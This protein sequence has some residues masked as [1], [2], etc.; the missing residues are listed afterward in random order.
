MTASLDNNRRKFLMTSAG[1]GA[2]VRP[3]LRRAWRGARAQGLHGA[4]AAAVRQGVGVMPPFSDKL[5]PEQIEAVA[6][7]VAKSAGK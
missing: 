3:V 7:F 4:G 5:T 6:R 1:G 2:R